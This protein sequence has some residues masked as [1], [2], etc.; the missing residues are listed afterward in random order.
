MNKKKLGVTLGS[1][2]LVGAIGF[3]AT[4]A[5]LSDQTQTLNN[6]FVIGDKI[7]IELDEK[8]ITSTTGERTQ[9]GND[10]LNVLPG[11][12][13]EKDPTVTFNTPTTEAYVFM[14]MKES[15]DVTPVKINPVW[16][17]V[18]DKTLPEG[19]KVYRYQTT[20]NNDTVDFNQS[21]EG[22]Q[23]PALFTEAVLRANHD[24]SSDIDNFKVSAAAIQSGG[25][26]ED[27]AY[28][29]LRNFLVSVR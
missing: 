8:D 22:K 26:T 19:V 27:E 24:G 16:V 4:L 2:A 23:L 3:G 10:Y 7:D 21:V 12:E 29:E 9:E 5:Y 20:I 13:F 11:V 17:E 18:E 25:L 14:A 6:T 28:A 1:L 15:K